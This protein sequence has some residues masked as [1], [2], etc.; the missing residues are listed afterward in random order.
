MS[1]L[2]DDW[3]RSQTPAPPQR[4]SRECRSARRLI[5]PPVQLS[6]VETVRPLAF[7]SAKKSCNIN[8][9]SPRTPCEKAPPA[10]STPIA[11]IAPAMISSIMTPNGPFL[12]S[13]QPTGPGFQMSNRRNST[14]AAIQPGQRAVMFSPCSHAGNDSAQSDQH[15]TGKFIQYKFR[16]VQ[17]VLAFGHI[18]GRPKTNAGGKSDRG[19]RDQQGKPPMAWMAHVAGRVTSDPHVPGAGFK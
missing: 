16:R 13:A 19:G 2:G 3:N 7:A 12:R 9:H 15:L 10:G 18:S 14:N 6:A 17:I 11:A 1:C 4:K 8:R 5:M